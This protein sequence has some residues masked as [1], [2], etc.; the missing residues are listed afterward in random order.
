M[1]GIE[2]DSDG[3]ITRWEP[4]DTGKHNVKRLVVK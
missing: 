1:D 3:F 2:Q 4:N